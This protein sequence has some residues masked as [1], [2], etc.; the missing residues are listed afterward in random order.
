[1]LA[2]G[3]FWMFKVTPDPLGVLHSK[4]LK[5]D[6][7]DEMQFAAQLA[8]QVPMLVLSE[9]PARLEFEQLNQVLIELLSSRGA[10]PKT[11]F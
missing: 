1:M 8:A 3:Y 7:G 10:S 5:V 9:E 11:S 2:A 6:L 4:Q